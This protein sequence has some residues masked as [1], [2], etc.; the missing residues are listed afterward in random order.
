MRRLAAAVLALS[1]VAACSPK[2][3]V[4][5]DSFDPA[6]HMFL[7]EVEGGQALDWVRAQNDRSLK[8]L[9]EDARYQGYYDT[10]L[11]IATSKER[12]PYGSIRNGFVYNFWQDESHERGLWRRTTVAQYGSAAPVW[13]TLLDVDALAKAEGAN[14][15]YKG[16]SCLPPAYS[17]C[18]VELSD[19]GKDAA[20]QREFDLGTKS[21]VAG[22]D[23][24]EAKTSAE[25]QDKDTLL[26]A[27]DWGPEGGQATLTDSGYPF[28]VKRLKRGQKLAE[29]S[30]VFRGTKENVG[31][32]PLVIEDSSGK[33]HFG[34][35]Q[36]ETFFTSS[37]FYFPETGGAP[38]KF[39]LPPKATPQGVFADTLLVTL[40]QDWQPEGQGAFKVGDLIGFRWSEFAASGKLPKVEL[41]V[42]PNERQA[43]QGVGI[44][45]GAVLVNLSDNVVLK[46]LAYTKAGAAWSSK[47]IPL[48]EKGAASVVFSD[49]DEKTAYLGFEGFLQPDALYQ[50]ESDT[51]A[52]K[53]IKSLPAWF[54]ASPYQVDQYEATSKDGTKVPYFVVHKKDIALDGSNP[55][56]LYGYGGFQVSETPAYSGT[57]GKLWLEQGGVYVLANIRGG[58]EFGPAWHQAGLKTKRQVVYDDFIGVAEDLIA[59]KITSSEKLGAMGGS[60]GGLLMGVMFTQRP[61]LFKAIVCQVPLLDMLRY[62]QLLAGASWMDEYG[63]PDVPEERAFL[64]KTSPYHNVKAG[65]AYPEIY[66]ETSTKDDRVH[67]GHARKMAKRL[68]ELGKPFFYYENIDGGH[69]AAANQREAARRAAL[70]YT[71]LARKLIEGK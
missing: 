45:K 42:R 66:F 10:A 30:E 62:N 65:V 57:A 25:W 19:G 67:P 43:I 38:V 6:S 54:D 29:A 12:I 32:F 60:N 71:Y 47:E 8:V 39:P 7:E 56:L 17:D 68:E 70:E 23:I 46:V 1:V 50:Y 40:E 36:A 4:V 49:E 15:V 51:G 44:S 5:T 24:P 61:D 34:A 55:T 2:E 11:K 3:T 33:R 18:I 27:T 26:I 16:V 21:F 22:F 14:W 13:E 64:E 28:V 20:R 52:L 63:D 37:Y 53:Q 58:G 69:S 35:V 9:Q 31:A 41:V 59:R 48:P